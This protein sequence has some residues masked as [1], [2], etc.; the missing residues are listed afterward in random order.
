MKE[1]ITI[2]CSN[3]EWNPDGE[4]LW[5]CSCGHNWNT[6]ETEGKCPNCKKQWENTVCPCCNQLTPHKDWYKTKKE[7]EEIEKSGDPILRKKKKS[8]E[9]RLINYGINNY[10]ITHLAYLE[11]NNV[12]FQTPYDAGCRMM[13]LYAIGYSVHELEARK[14]IAEWMKEENIWNK[15]SPNEKEYFE[16]KEPNENTLAN[17]SWRVES[18]LT[19]GWCLNKVQKLPKLDNNNNEEEIEEFQ[20]NVPRLGDS[21]SQFLSG[22]AYR[23]LGEVYEENL[24]NELVTSYFRDLMFNGRENK[25]KINRMISYERHHTLNWIRKFSGIDEWDETNTST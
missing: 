7:I 24:L 15:V 13:I 22:L 14:S 18:A 16:D 10:R 5:K 21:L 4:E 23:E 11:Y 25:T 8:L 12:D 1:D 17:L 9:S 6:F 3:C 20:K 2:Q 19:L